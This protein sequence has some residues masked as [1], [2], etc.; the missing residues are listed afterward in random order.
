MLSHLTPLTLA[1][2]IYIL[3]LTAAVFAFA[4]TPMTEK[5]ASLFARHS[6]KWL[7]LFV[8]LA[9]LTF[10]SADSGEILALSFLLLLLPL[11]IAAG[12][13]LLG[14]RHIRNFSLVFLAYLAATVITDSVVFG[15]AF[16]TF[17]FFAL[18]I[19]TL[20]TRK[21]L[22]FIVRYVRDCILMAGEIIRLRV[23]YIK[24]RYAKG[25]E[26][27][28]ILFYPELP[29]LPKSLHIA[30]KMCMTHGIKMSRSP[31]VAADAVVAF[32]DV[33]LREDN[34]TLQELARTR[35]VVNFNCK[36]ISKT[37]VE[38]I[39]REVFGYGTFVDPRT[40]T[41]KC[42]K[43]SDA[44]ATHDG[45][46]INCPAEP[47]EGYIYQKLIENEVD[48]SAM[49]FRVPV[50]AGVVPLVFRRFNL[51]GERFTRTWRSDMLDPREE[52]NKDELAKIALFCE[53]FGLDFG[54]LDVMRDM[55]DG[56]IYILDVNNTPSGPARVKDLPG[57]EWD[58][59]IG[60]VYDLFKKNFL[61]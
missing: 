19:V 11:N 38:K 17:E 14:L 35:T 5:Q 22:L 16:L 45:E 2:A 23:T 3:P 25:A 30:Y 8:V 52:Y 13:L 4:R 21:T 34:Q 12:T 49:I 47:E 39:S 41:G 54:E 58:Y 18:A 55:Y 7:G 48:G 9:L 51:L 33:T 32:A 56:R 37:Q 46:I 24:A 57:K 27:R 44:N 26:K 59:Y 61:P 60:A 43:K 10:L 15:Q 42:V 28:T 53:K 50:V 20:R 31:N 29:K 40:F 6:V 36:D 1:A